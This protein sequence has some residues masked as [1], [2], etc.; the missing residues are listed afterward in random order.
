MRNMERWLPNFSFEIYNEFGEFPF[1]V[2][3]NKVDVADEKKV[4]AVEEFV[5]AKGL[6]PVR[7]SALNGEGL[8]E[9]KK[10]VIEMV[11]PKAMELARKVMKREL[12]KFRDGL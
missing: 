1:I 3:I 5:K 12:S 9:L 11:E 7:I 6:E 4:R 10:R 8:E 2:A